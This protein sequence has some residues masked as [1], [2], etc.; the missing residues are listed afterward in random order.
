M[1]MTGKTPMQKVGWQRGAALFTALIMMI[2][3]SLVALA[4]LSTGL[5]ELR[6]SGNEEMAMSAFQSAQAG[7]D[8]I[9]NDA[10]SS[11]QFSVASGGR[12]ATNCYN[13]PDACTST[14]AASSLPA[15]VNTTDYQIKITQVVA[16]GAPPP[17]RLFPTSARLFS[18]ASFEVES[19][20]DRSSV[21]RGK[22]V[23]A[24]GYF[25]LLPLP[26]GGIPPTPQTGN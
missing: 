3:L 17:S 20:F 7:V 8:V 11:Q 19:R 12:G 9:V 1:N 22:A 23:A 16:S 6:M 24:Q 25:Q 2:A 13:W 4:S 5:L 26:P 15:P 14:I 10:L 21:G 18:A